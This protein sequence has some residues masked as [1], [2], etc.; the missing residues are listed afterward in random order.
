MVGC[1][2]QKLRCNEEKIR[3]VC[4]YYLQ[5]YTL[6]LVSG[7]SGERIDSICPRNLVT[8]PCSEYS[9]ILYGTTIIYRK[10]NFDRSFVN[11]MIDHSHQC[12][13]AGANKCLNVVWRNTKRY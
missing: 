2:E 10:T 4:R 8:H 5:R 7:H 3:F 6:N 12:L 11:V 13:I 9:I 1:D